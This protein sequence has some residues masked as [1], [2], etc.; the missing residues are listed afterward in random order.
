ME[1]CQTFGFT[2]NLIKADVED[3][4]SQERLIKLANKFIGTI[5]N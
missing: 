1:W 4:A 5:L 2:N 3:L